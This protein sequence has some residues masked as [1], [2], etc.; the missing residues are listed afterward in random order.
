MQVL[1][2]N[3]GEM[4]SLLTRFHRVAKVGFGTPA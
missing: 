4:T 2:E 1:A 3:M